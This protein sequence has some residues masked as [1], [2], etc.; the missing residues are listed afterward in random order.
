LTEIAA[1]MLTMTPSSTAVTGWPVSRAIPV[2]T[3]NEAT[4]L[5][6]A[7]PA[8]RSRSSPGSDATS[9]SRNRL[10]TSRSVATAPMLARAT[11]ATRHEGQRSSGSQL[12]WHPRWI[13]WLV[14]IRDSFRC[15]A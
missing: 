10:L 13:C 6:V 5:A 14:T 12:R 11:A 15:A 9:A 4:M 1:T 2:I 8:S 7:V 3:P